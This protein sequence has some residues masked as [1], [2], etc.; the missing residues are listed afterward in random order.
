MARTKLDLI[1]LAPPVLFPVENYDQA[2]ALLVL[3]ACERYRKTNKARNDLNDQLRVVSEK[4]R[5]HRAR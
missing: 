1:V 3:A 5:A 4:G 2:E